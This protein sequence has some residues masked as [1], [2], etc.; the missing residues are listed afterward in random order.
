MGLLVSMWVGLP[1]RDVAGACNENVDMLF[2]LPVKIVFFKLLLSLRALADKD[3][4]KKI[5]NKF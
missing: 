5:E 1:V 3:L 4:E 2:L